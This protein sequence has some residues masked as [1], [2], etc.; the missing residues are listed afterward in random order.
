[1]TVDPIESA[2][3]GQARQSRTGLDA[4]VD[5]ATPGRDDS[6]DY[7]AYWQARSG[8]FDRVPDRIPNQP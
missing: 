8:F 4:P 6:N 1:M 7:A 5:P 2:E 3:T